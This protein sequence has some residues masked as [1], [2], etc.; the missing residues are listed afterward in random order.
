MGEVSR[1]ENNN[2]TSIALEKDYSSHSM[3]NGQWKKKSGSI[4]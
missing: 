4:S 2:S 3:V 1:K